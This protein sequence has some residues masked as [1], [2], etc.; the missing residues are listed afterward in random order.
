MDPAA[1]TILVAVKLVLQ[2]PFPHTRI[3]APAVLSVAPPSYSTG[4]EALKLT[5]T[6]PQLGESILTWVA[7]LSPTMVP[8]MIGASVG[9]GLG[10][11][12]AI[13][14]AV[15]VDAAMGAW[16]GAALDVG[17][18]NTFGTGCIGD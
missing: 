15:G 11:D 8:S 6:Y 18:A 17:M 16:V 4:V 10:V 2:L 12:L 1:T 7:L 13:G 14:L 3:D 5:F 9:A